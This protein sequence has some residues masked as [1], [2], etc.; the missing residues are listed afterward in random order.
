MK[1]SHREL[2]RP[3]L[4]L[5]SCVI[6]VIYILISALLVF[7]AFYMCSEMGDDVHRR[8]LQE[9]KKSVK[10]EVI[11]ARREYSNIVNYLSDVVKQVLFPYLG[12]HWQIICFEV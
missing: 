11:K 7:Y 10:A 12:D 4:C 9:R 5:N 2:L 3:W 6:C 8:F 1:I